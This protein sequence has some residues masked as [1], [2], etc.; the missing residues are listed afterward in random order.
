MLLRLLYLNIAPL[1]FSKSGLHSWVTDVYVS[2]P[3]RGRTACWLCDQIVLS[4]KFSHV[5]IMCS[6][7][8]LQQTS[9]ASVSHFV[10]ATHAMSFN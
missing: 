2:Q 1:I 9:T 6:I 8:I 4:G 3:Y 10:C 7:W 5:S